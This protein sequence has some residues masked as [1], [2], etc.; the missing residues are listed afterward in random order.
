[1]ELIHKYFPKLSDWQMDRFT[2]LVE[3]YNYWNRQINLISRKDIEHLIERH[4]LHSLALM[5]WRVFL[6]PGSILDVG[7]GGGFPG[8][9][10]AIA[11]QENE[12]TLIDGVARKI[13]VVNEIISALD[14]KNAR[15]IQTRVEDHKPRYH[16]IV[17]R[18][19]TKLPA[20]FRLV[21]KNMH[22]QM[23]DESFG[24]YY[25]KGGD[26][27][28]EL[29]ELPVKPDIYNISD[30]FDEPFFSTKKIIHIPAAG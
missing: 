22:T 3:L 16:Y 27:R 30:C 7:T 19:V 17:S 13:K 26:L 24:I 11:C 2:R 25:Y 9:P 4:I 18:A 10:L 21:K 28:D 1:M 15:G 6:R 5:K 29:A 23:M 14:L 8:I 12:F 20:F